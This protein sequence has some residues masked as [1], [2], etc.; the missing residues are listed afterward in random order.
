MSSLSSLNKAPLALGFFGGSFDPVHVA[1]IEMAVAVQRALGLAEVRLMPCR[2]PPHKQGLHASAE[3]RVAMTQLALVEY[4]RTHT[5][6]G[7]LLVDTRELKREGP[8]YTRQTVEAIRHEF[9]PTA[10]LHFILGWDSW[11][12]FTQWYQ[13]QEILSYVNLVLV[14]RPGYSAQLAEPLQQLLQERSVD[15]AEALAHT[16]GK[17]IEVA[18]EQRDL[19]SSDIRQTIARGEST[20]RQLYSSVANYI[21]QHK[22]Y[23]AG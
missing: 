23:N 11:E 15:P 9:G 1:H 8:S 17:I 10:S 4:Q 6:A 13:W 18:T 16:A 3:Q 21:A 19:A 5:H 2:I 22:L 20:R 7:R 14:R 12:N